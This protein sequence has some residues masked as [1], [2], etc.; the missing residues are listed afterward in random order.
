MIKFD[1]FLHKIFIDIFSLI[2]NYCTNTN[3]LSTNIDSN[4]LKKK[5]QSSNNQY[6]A[7]ILGE[8]LYTKI[9]NYLT[10][11]LEKICQVKFRLI[12]CN[13]YQ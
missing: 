1:S 5:K 7:N 9:K 8:E 13:I 2:Y 12:S 3:H 4:Q 6:E 10:D 11:Y